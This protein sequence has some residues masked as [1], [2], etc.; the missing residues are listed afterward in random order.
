MIEVLGSH[1][2]EH[3]KILENY[4]DTFD[5]TG[6]SVVE[7]LRLLVSNFL[8]F[9]ESQMIERVVDHLTKKYCK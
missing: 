3:V 8:L 2:E 7:S 1:K 5:F 4:I 9:G 6:L